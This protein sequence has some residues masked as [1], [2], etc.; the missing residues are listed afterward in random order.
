VQIVVNGSPREIAGSPTVAQLLA[1]LGLEGAR[2]AVAVN[3]DVVP[4]G[5]HAEVLLQPG[6]R[7]EIVAAVQ[8]G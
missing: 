3:R 2:I 6:D 4:R 5:R 1:E 8:G 7:V